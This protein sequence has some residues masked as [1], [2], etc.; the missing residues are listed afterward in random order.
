MVA[1]KTT[2]YR[3]RK[4]GFTLI[5]LLVVIAIIAVLIALLLPAVQQAREAARRTQC[6]NNLKQIGLAFHNYHDTFSQFPAALTFIGNTSPGIIS[7]HIG[8]GL[9]NLPPSERESDNVHVW[10]EMLLPFMDQG[11]LY[12]TINFSVPMGFGTISGGPITS[13]VNGGPYVGTQ[14]FAAIASSVI[15]SFICPSA[16]RGSNSNAPY[17]NDWWASSFS[18]N[19]MY[20]AGGALDYKAASASGSMNSAN[21]NKTM[22][23]GD[24]NGT[25]SKAA[26]ALGIKIASVP[27]GLSNTILLGECANTANQWAMGKKIGPTSES[28]ILDSAGKQALGGDSWNDWQMGIMLVR[29]L[30]PGSVI[31]ARSGGQCTINCNNHWNWY[32]MHVGGAH[33]VLGDGSVRFLSQS[34]PQQTM[35]NLLIVDDGNVLGEF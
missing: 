24:M 14:N 9:Y 11:N 27:D 34:L 12:N 28:G 1:L 8:Q 33:F 10:T 21:S 2:T 26:R 18:G 15:P 13:P 7:S 31:G 32:S 4:Q 30:A 5:E 35:V 6:K 23:N 19:S 20:H 17:L 3:N 25:N 16:P 29:A 22:L